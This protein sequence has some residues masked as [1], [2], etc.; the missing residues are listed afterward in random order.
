MSL[1]DQLKARI[2]EAQYLQKNLADALVEQ[3]VAE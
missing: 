1:C 2:R 3:V